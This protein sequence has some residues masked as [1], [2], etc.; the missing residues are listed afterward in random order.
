MRI[1]VLYKGVLVA[2]TLCV[3]PA[4]LPAAPRAGQPGADRVESGKGAFA[5]NA[6][7]LLQEVQIDAFRVRDNAEQLQEQLRI[8]SQ[9]DWM[10]DGDLLERVRDRVNEMDKLLSQLRENQAAASPWQQKAI[11][12]I[13]PS[14]VN[15]TDTTQAAI[16][17]LN[18]NHG[19]VGL[20]D[21]PG[22]ARDISDRASQIVRATGDFERYANARHELRQ[23]EQTLEL[24]GS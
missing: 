24:K 21:L 6:S 23:L 7:N 15:L 16:V 19:R 9:N 20:S 11:E 12:R 8:P 10:S 3:A 5:I 13:A 2:V 22:L 17:T 1:N 18:D 4:A 14:V